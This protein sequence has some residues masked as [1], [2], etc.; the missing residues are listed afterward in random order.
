M[1][2]ENQES[3]LGADEFI[4]LLRSTQPAPAQPM[5]SA[6]IT[7]ENFRQMM[8]NAPKPEGMSWLD[9]PVQ[10]ITNIPKSGYEFGK[11][12][13]EAITSPVESVKS[14]LDVG[15]GALRNITP[16][17]IVEFIDRY[18]ANPEAAQR[19]SDTASQLGKFYKER[20]GSSEGFKQAL[21]ND[22]V[23]VAADISTL[24]TGTGAAIRPVSQ[25]GQIAKLSQALRTAG[26]VTNPLL[27]ATKSAEKIVSPT[28]GLLTGTSAETVRQ[29]AKAGFQSAYDKTS[30]FLE[31]L[32][33]RGVM[34]QP[35]EDAR[36]NLIVMRQNRS[37]AYR[38][39]MIDISADKTVLDFNDIDKALANAKAQIEFKGKVKDE[40]AK[41][42]YDKIESEIADWKK[43]NPAD[44]HT[45]EG[46]DALK[47]KIG[48][49]VDSVP[50][51]ERNSL[52]I[53]ND[54]YNATK[55]TISKQAPKY[56]EVM[57][58]YAEASDQIKEIE[59]ALSLG[60]RASA[61]TAMRKLQSLNRNNV[62]TNYGNRLNLAQTLEAE[63]GKPFISALAGQSLSSPTARGLAGGV[64]ALTMLGG[65]YNPA[66]LASIP[67]QTPRVVGEVAYAGGRA[68]RPV[69]DI[70]RRLGVSPAGALALSDLLKTSQEIKP[71]DLFYLRDV[72]NLGQP[73]R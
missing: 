7:A 31:Q 56:A 53:G 18:E 3:F 70:S 47:Q 4:N 21:A 62:Y 40:R 45:P 34:T 57:R 68:A 71:E 8:R 51:D 15:A 14:L 17:Q 32:R 55:A 23:G 50:I 33:G 58:D 67:F 6:D 46:L 42:F 49:I 5:P 52:R 16:R 63:G 72:M 37:N 10:A 60:N 35:L 65:L 66:Y 38:S 11:G 43:E 61:D 9:V 27:M 69:A 19:A 36:H 26:D 2:N 13:Y 30:P 48:A 1:A 64:E 20:Y 12:M 44:Y 73:N 29:A 22:P 39:G 28:L 24:F 54:I 59:R 41:T 25:T